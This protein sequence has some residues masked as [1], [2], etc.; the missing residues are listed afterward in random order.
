MPRRRSMSRTCEDFGRDGLRSGPGRATGISTSPSPGSALSPAGRHRRRPRGR[1]TGL[2]RPRPRSAPTLSPPQTPPIG[3][4]PGL[5]AP[6]TWH[7]GRTP[8]AARSLEGEVAMAVCTR[9][10]FD[11]GTSRQHESIDAHLNVRTDP[12]EGLILHASGPVEGGWA[13]FDVWETHDA[14]ERFAASRAFPAGLDTRPARARGV[15][16]GGGGPAGPHADRGPA[17]RPGR[18][19]RLRRSAGTPGRPHDSRCV[20]APCPHAPPQTPLRAPG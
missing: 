19:S 11:C 5:R 10:R 4:C 6:Q 14:F 20:G 9:L 16:G 2:L 15:H 18:D 17:V 7:T 12:P 3:G 1:L 13:M 8:Q